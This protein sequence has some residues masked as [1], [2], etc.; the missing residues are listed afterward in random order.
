MGQDIENQ[1]RVVIHA[2][3]L[4]KGAGMKPLKHENIAP[5]L[6]TWKTERY[7]MA[8]QEYYVFE[9]ILHHYSK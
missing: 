3:P 4:E 2:I 8:V 7:S 1:K 9:S 6:S 5:V